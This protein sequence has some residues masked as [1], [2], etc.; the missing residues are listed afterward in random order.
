MSGWYV[1]AGLLILAV[2]YDASAAWGGVVLI[3]LVLGMLGVG[4]QAGVLNFT[5]GS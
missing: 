5:Q 2:V 4:S 1:F 3:I